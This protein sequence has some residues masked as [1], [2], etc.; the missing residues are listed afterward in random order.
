MRVSS[1]KRRGLGV[2]LHNDAK[3]ENIPDDYTHPSFTST[4]PPCG[5]LVQTSS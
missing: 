4:H 2:Q 1:E 3:L 5:Y